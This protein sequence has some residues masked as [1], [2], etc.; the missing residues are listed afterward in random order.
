V[1]AGG[2]RGSGRLDGIGCRGSDLLETLGDKRRLACGCELG[3]EEAI[4]RGGRRVGEVMGDGR[5]VGRS[6]SREV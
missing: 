1:S 5:I 6:R 4:A 2:S 3:M